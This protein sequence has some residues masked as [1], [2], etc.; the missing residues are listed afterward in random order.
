MARLGI[1]SDTHGLLRPEALAFLQGSD[2]ILHAG[3][4][5]RAEVLTR[6]S[7]IA[8]VTAVRGNI[9]KGA[10]AE[11]IRETE[12]LEFGGLSIYAIHD[13]SRLRIDPAV[14]IH[15]V[16][17]GHSHKPGIERREDIIF[18]N[19][20]SA[21]PRRFKLPISVAELIIEGGSIASS[22]ILEL[23]PGG[24]PRLLGCGHLKVSRGSL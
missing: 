16:A 18:I 21:G 2:R 1:I 6:L 15:V 11:A 20:G 22:R 3:D 23:Q 4:I 13:V 5:G 10:W 17:S 9:D 8:P 19:P 24:W 14:R 12:L 7:A